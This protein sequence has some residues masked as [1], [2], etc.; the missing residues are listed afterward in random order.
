[1]ATHIKL[2]DNNNKNVSLAAMQRH[3]L[4]DQERRQ[5]QH[6]FKIYMEKYFKDKLQRGDKTKI[7]IGTICWLSGARF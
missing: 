1:M 5:L 4:N 3:R 6:E 2:V 7:V